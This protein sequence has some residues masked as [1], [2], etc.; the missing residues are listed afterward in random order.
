M[1]STTTICECLCLNIIEQTIRYGVMPKRLDLRLCFA[2]IVKPRVVNPALGVT[3]H[4]I[5]LL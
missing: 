5:V 2:S 3:F 4:P 1:M